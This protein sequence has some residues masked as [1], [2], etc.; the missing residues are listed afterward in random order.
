MGATSFENE[1]R[2]AATMQ[3]AYRELVEQ[4]F[5][6]QG[7]DPYNGT[8]STTNGVMQDPG[9]TSPVDLNAAMVRA[10]FWDREDD[11]NEVTPQKWEAAFAVPLLPDDK[12]QP[13]WLFYGL[14]A[15]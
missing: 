15:C 8:I 4:A 11:E 12:G 5:Y 10:R 9:V 6:D 13:G 7:H 3:D 14:A 2:G 1:Y